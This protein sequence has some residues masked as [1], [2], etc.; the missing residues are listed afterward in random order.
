MPVMLDMMN[1]IQIYVL[2][3]NMEIR[4]MAIAKT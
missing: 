3:G 2:M 1:Y 4:V